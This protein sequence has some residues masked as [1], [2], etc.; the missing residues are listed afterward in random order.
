[1]A[2]ELKSHVVVTRYTAPN[3]KLIVH[4]YGPYTEA[5]AVRVR[6]ETRKAY[7]DFIDS[8]KMEVYALRI[9]DVDSMNGRSS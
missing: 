2:H 4:A 3:G 5:A 1:M 9:L 7:K 6:R 8:G